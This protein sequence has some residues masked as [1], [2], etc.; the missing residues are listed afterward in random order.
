MKQ[1]RLRATT[2]QGKIGNFIAQ[3]LPCIFGAQ[4]LFLP[5][6]VYSSMF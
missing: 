5:I 3:K 1:R 4:I 2:L 6:I